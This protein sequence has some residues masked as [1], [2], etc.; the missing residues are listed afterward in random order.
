MEAPYSCGER[1]GLTIR[2]MVLG[3]KFKS[4]L[5][6]KL[7]GKDGLL[8]GRKNNENNKVTTKNIFLNVMLTLK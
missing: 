2:A 1:Q 7:D 6:L 4:R 3:R 8:V 5:H